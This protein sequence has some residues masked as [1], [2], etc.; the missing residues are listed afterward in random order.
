M[1][2]F[3]SRTATFCLT[4]LALCPLA[5][6]ALDN[7]SVPADAKWVIHLDLDAVRESPV[8]KEL[9]ALIEK[10]AELP[11]TANIQ[12][13]VK[14]VIASISSA[15]AYGTTFS[16][17]PKEI[18][19][20]LVL[21]GTDD[22]RKIAEA[23]VTQFSIS[24]PEIVTEVKGLPFPAYS[25]KNEVTV[26]FPTEPI[27]LLSRSQ[28]QL[29]KGYDL[30]RGKG[31]AAARGT[32]SLKGLIPKTRPLLVFAASEVPNTDGLFPENQPQAR[33]LKMA[34]SAAI[35]IGQ[36]EKLTTATIQLV[37]ADDDLSDKLHKIVQ[38]L[39]AM[40]SLAQ[41]EDQQLNTFLQSVKTERNGRNIVVSLS[42]PTDGLLQ[43]IRSIEASENR[44]NQNRNN[45]NN[46]RQPP[47]SSIPG[48][49]VS[50]WKA[51]KPTGNA[52]IAPETL[53]TQNIPN[54]P[55][56]NGT[57]IF[58]CG[59]RDGGENAR[60]DYIDIVPS[61][62]GSPAHIEA[63]TMTLNHYRVEKN[64]AASG[65]KCIILENNATGY[66]QVVFQ[67][68]DGMYNLSV[69]YVDENDGVAT[70]TVSTRDPEAA[71]SESTGNA[72]PGAPQPPT[73]PA[74]A[75]APSAK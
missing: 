14:K 5:H 22:L 17:N 54:V 64:A 46:N 26:A 23:V 32:S 73:P 10:N 60:Y 28:Q 2:A 58:L 56:K 39:V 33:I 74:P 70:F 65:G 48:K 75:V 24:N 4:T 12:I 1:K 66:A 31:P 15:T 16:K 3:L 61:A 62:G 9:V 34:K 7:N 21:Q 68:V 59:Q 19:G 41:S 63:E 69:R 18:D 29:L 57:V 35:A 52:G 27:I 37:A 43:M 72:A 8:G 11:K 50:T 6:A 55:L 45:D 40:L 44:Q 25:I 53:F 51:D 30:F 42:Y 38:G 36:N 67:G 49:V 13:D 20:T 47:K 71:A